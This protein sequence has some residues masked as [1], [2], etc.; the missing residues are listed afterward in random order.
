MDRVALNNLVPDLKELFKANV[1]VMSYQAACALSNE[2]R[3][4]LFEEKAEESQGE[5]AEDK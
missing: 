4:V 2:M 3:D 5:S 1:Q